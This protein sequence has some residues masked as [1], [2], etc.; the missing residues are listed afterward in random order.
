MGNL[1][2]FFI[3]LT[4]IFPILL[5]VP[6]WNLA[7]SG[8]ELPGGT[9]S[10]EYLVVERDMY[11]LNT[12][13][14]KKIVVSGSNI[15]ITHRFVATYDTSHIE[16]GDVDFDN[17]ESSY[18]ERLSTPVICPKGK[19]H[20]YDIVRKEYIIPNDFEEKGDWELKCFMQ[21]EKYFLVLYKMNGEYNFYATTS[22]VYNL[23]RIN[24]FFGE[25]LYDF[26]LRNEPNDQEPFPMASIIK[27]NNN[28]VL[29][30]SKLYNSQG[31]NITD[32]GTKIITDA[33]K[34]SQVVF[35]NY[36]QNFYFFTYNNVSDFTCGYTSQYANSSNYHNVT[37][38]TF[39]K[40]SESPLI[41]EGNVEIL[42]MNFSLYNKYAFYKI[43]N[44]DKNI[45]Y[46][47]VIDVTLNKVIF[48][49]KEQIQSFSAF[50]N[51]SMLAIVNN[52]AYRICG[53]KNA[54]GTDC[55][56]SCEA[57]NPK[58]VLDLENGNTCSSSTGCS[59][60]KIMLIPSEACTSNCDL[61]KFIKNNTHCGGCKY[62][63]ENKIYKFNDNTVSECL[64]SIPVG[65]EESD[66][67]FH[68]LQCKSGYIF[69]GTTC[70]TH[71]FGTCL[72]CSDYSTDE[73]N[74]KCLSCGSGYSLINGN[75]IPLSNCLSQTQE[76][77]AAC[78][79][80]SNLN[81]LCVSCNPG[82]LKANYTIV[83]SEFLDCFKEGDPLF[84][85][86]Y[87]D[88]NVDQY[89]PCY[90]TCKRCLKPGNRTAQ[91]CLE[92][93]YDLMLKPWDN[94]YNN[95]VAYSEYYYRNSFDQIKNLDIFQ[96]PEEAKYVVKG[97][98]FCIDDCKKNSDYK[99]L[100]NGNCVQN[101]PFDNILNSNNYVC[102]VNPNKCILG[103]NAIY[104]KNNNLDFIE[105]LV[106]TY[107]SEFNYTDN[108]ISLYE[109]SENTNYTII[110]YK[111]SECIKELGLTMP[112]IIFNECYKK[113][114]QAYG[115]NENLIVSLA[116]KVEN[117][118]P[119]T[120]TALYH[121]KSGL[122]LDAE[123]ICKNDTITIW[124]NLQSFFDKSDDLKYN[125]LKQ[126]INIFDQDS[127]F[128]TDICY[129]FDNP[130]K[131]DITL[132]DRVKLVFNDVTLCDEGSD[133]KGINYENMSVKC[134][135]SFN[136]LANNEIIKD[137][138]FLSNSIGEIF[139]LISS[140]NIYVFKCTKYIFK[141]FTRSIGSFLCLVAIASHIGLTLLYF[142]HGKIKL[143]IYIFSITNSYLLYLKKHGKNNDK[144]KH[145]PSKRGSK[146]KE[147]KSLKSNLTSINEM[148]SFNALRQTRSNIELNIRKKSALPIIIHKN[149]K[150]NTQR[151]DKKNNEKEIK[152]EV[153]KRKSKMHIEKNDNF[154]SQ[155]LFP[156]NKMT[157]FFQEFMETSPDD[158]EY[159][160]AIVLDKR[161]FSE[162]LKEN[163]KDNQ[164]IANTFIAENPLKPRS[165]KIILF[166]LNLLLY[167]VVDALFIN[168]EVVEEIFH[169]DEEKE[170][171]FSYLPRSIDEIFYAALVSIVIGIV[172]DFFFV[173][174]KKI[175]GIFKREKDNQVI[176]K[177]D[178]LELMKDIQKRY[179]AL[180]I[181]V[182]IVIVLSFY[183][184]LCFNY[185]FPYT[186]MEWIK[187]SVTIVIF[188]Q[189]ISI[190]RCVAS[191][192]LR[193]MSFK[194]ESEK[195]YKY[196]KLL[197]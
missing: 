101:C 124:G 115:I 76:K 144:E 78:N 47:G 22:D 93:K 91:N 10:K 169:A 184:L 129:D 196:G 48:N 178:M 154:I 12:K 50:F 21:V 92:C 64:E 32:E 35:Q 165:I 69:N 16:S 33:K 188:M 172:E 113:V 133:N 180:V 192:G 89:R 42:E 52:K 39:V 104:L 98:N 90:K 128:F 24:D 140:S 3:F 127:D 116:S 88:E 103:R 195:L 80:Q 28:L 81:K 120:K 126:G 190:L 161:K 110:I 71:C 70:E 191:S 95:C 75:C 63:Y 164:I 177:K 9:T 151:N 79:S 108:F 23:T 142:L 4:F 185:A 125:L 109:N 15:V 38:Y 145:E 173:E 135:C 186:Q 141:Y 143:K 61:Y 53:I 56:D 150:K 134:D 62:F 111:N 67:D 58:T 170:N 171:F 94:P 68:L 85:N 51:N 112:Y 114:Q 179:F 87:H 163:L 189:I 157:E 182:S 27:L 149:I 148:K 146:R 100:Y 197:L 77:C 123:N 167:F 158:M 99:F 168:E 96:C 105:T 160:D 107:S 176:L 122:K 5:Y 121:P 138:V 102:K 17:I 6:E 7:T 13:L 139:D 41:F 30:G 147:K 59:N 106:K 37:K 175:R 44:K 118:K 66:K 1:I 2:L 8:I 131:K 31:I 117:D 40:Y 20:M 174:E 83:Y 25:E 86:F 14:Y 72:T 57:T 34:Y 11:Q 65:A 153:K 18:K 166:M 49:T 152:I 162:H 55:L 82:Y 45:T 183:Y 46:T 159:D 137:N 156:K 194:F 43:Y 181:I 60:G 187:S 36:S 74:Q 136:D 29:K 119:I 19:Y 155:D 193:F 97:K 130:L 84:I 73:Q 132:N 26:I 54:A